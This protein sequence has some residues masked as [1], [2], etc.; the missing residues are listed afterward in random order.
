MA[1]VAFAPFTDLSGDVAGDFVAMLAALAVVIY[2]QIGE[3]LQKWDAIPIFPYLVVVNG[4]AAIM[5]YVYAVIWNVGDASDVV[6]WLYHSY[7]VYTVYLGIVPGI[8]GHA[9]FNY[10]LKII[11]PLIITIF[12]NLEPVIGSIIGWAFGFQAVPS[13]WTFVGGFLMIAGNMIVT[14]AEFKI[15]DQQEKERLLEEE[16]STPMSDMH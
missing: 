15:K 9:M 8:L 12:M 13:Y 10:L 11:S 6:A 14:I 4:I 16:R 7:G 2:L 5:S 1:L 3:N